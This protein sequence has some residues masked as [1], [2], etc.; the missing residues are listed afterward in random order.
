MHEALSIPA[1]RLAAL[2]IDLQEEHRADPRFIVADYAGVLARA[3]AI[4]TAARRQGVRV[5]HAAYVRDYERRPLRPF[6][7]TIPDGTP[8][9]SSKGS[10]LIAICPEV[11]P[12]DGEPVFE[13]ND[14]SAFCEG[15]LAPALAAAGVEWLLIAGVWTE[16]CVAATVRDAIA[17]GYRV[18]LVKDA[19]GSGTEAMHEVAIVNLANRLYGGAVV[20]SA[21]AG[22]LI[23]GESVRAWRVQG[24]APLRFDYETCRQVFRDL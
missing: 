15:D 24:A 18:L 22:R 19:C 14:A 1:D 16:A 3:G 5:L 11:A 17:L 20:D 10:P 12:A 23:A 7:P 9:F 8:A 6:E 13:K 2:F 21:A 4:Q